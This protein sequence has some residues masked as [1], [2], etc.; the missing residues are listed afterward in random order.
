[1]SEQ[2]NKDTTTTTNDNFSDDAS[3]NQINTDTD[4]NIDPQ[5]HNDNPPILLNSHIVPME[6][7]AQVHKSHR[8]QFMKKKLNAECEATH[9]YS[10]STTDSPLIITQEEPETRKEQARADEN[11]INRKTK[12]CK[13]YMK[14]QCEFGIKGKGCKFD[15]PKFC[16]KFLQHGTRMPRGCNKGKNCSD[17]HPKMCFSSLKSGI[18]LR[19]QM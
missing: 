15:H 19:Q 3:H 10:E 1:M 18:C 12:V 5:S 13:F 17:F 4:N 16:K 6:V 8:T 7:T 2:D 11:L 14:N 9:L